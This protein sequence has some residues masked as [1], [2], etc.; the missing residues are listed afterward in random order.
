MDAYAMSVQGFF[1]KPNT[2]SELEALLRTII[3]Y[4]QKCIAP[5]EFI[6]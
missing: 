1:Q 4:W 6:K 2:I 5:S 3:Q